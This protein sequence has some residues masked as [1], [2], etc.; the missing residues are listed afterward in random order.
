MSNSGRNIVI[1]LAVLAVATLVS[2]VIRER[3]KKTMFAL[4]SDVHN[5]ATAQLAYYMDHSTYA[6]EY[7]GGYRPTH[8]ASVVI[9]SATDT[10]WA[11]TATHPSTS[12]VCSI[13]YAAPRGATRAQ[14]AEAQTAMWKAYDCR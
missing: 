14:Q 3:N 1:V 6:A 4:Y 2:V 11:A 7:P 13:S 12:R 5:L 10:S 8:G 9:A